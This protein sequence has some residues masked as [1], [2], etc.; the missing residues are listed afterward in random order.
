LSFTKVSQAFDIDAMPEL[1][2]Q[3]IAGGGKELNISVIIIVPN[4]RS[5]IYGVV[6]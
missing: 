1:H 4:L 2:D 3:L 5:F 6:L